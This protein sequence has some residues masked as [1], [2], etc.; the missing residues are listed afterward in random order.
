LHRSAVSAILSVANDFNG[1]FGEQ[2]GRF[3]CRTIIDDQNVARITL[4]FI[5]NFRNV[6]LL[7]VNGNADKDSRTRVPGAWCELHRR[8]SFVNDS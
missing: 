7:V 4:H 5:E 6:M 2:S 3:I 1:R 8:N